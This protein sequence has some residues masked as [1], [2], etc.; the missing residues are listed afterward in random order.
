MCLRAGRST[1]GAPCADSRARSEESLQRRGGAGHDQHRADRAQQ[2]ALADGARS[3]V[4]RAARRA[5]TPPTDRE[6]VP[7]DAL[8]GVADHAGDADADAHGEVRA[9][10][11]R[12]YLAD[13]AQ[14]RRHPQRAEDQAHSPPSRPMPGPR[15]PRRGC[16]GPPACSARPPR[17]ARAAGRRR[18][19]A[20]VAPI[21]TAAPRPAAAPDIAADHGADHR[22]RRHP[23]EHPPVDPARADVD[24]RGGERPPR[25]R[26]RCWRRRPAAGLRRHEQHRG[27]A[28]VAEH[29][30]NDAASERDREAPGAEGDELERVHARRS[31][32]GR[33]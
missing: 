23:G 10:R 24:D 2:L 11:A 12:R 9:D 14:Q 17:R 21:V 32:P 26:C 18:S 29:E 20:S 7:V 22:R 8:G 27:E 19:R 4:S 31:L 6:Q 33:E 13:V 30:A 15:G 28:D 1:S 25:R 5:P 16:P 3:A